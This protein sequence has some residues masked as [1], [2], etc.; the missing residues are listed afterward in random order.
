VFWSVNP[1][2]FRV[3][4]AFHFE[5]KRAPVGVLLNPV[6]D[7]VEYKLSGPFHADVW[8]DSEIDDVFGVHRFKQR[9]FWIVGIDQ[10]GVIKPMTEPGFD[11][12]EFTKID[13]KP[14]L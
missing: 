9:H 4:P 5:H 12:F 7:V 2:V 13:A 8:Q 11:L 14:S 10:C 3:L 1:C 6:I